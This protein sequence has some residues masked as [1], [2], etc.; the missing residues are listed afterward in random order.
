MFLDVTNAKIPGRKRPNRQE[1]AAIEK[2]SDNFL[3][4]D[5]VSQRQ[6]GLCHV[7]QK[8]GGHLIVSKSITRCFRICKVYTRVLYF[9]YLC[10]VFD[11]SWPPA[12]GGRC[13]GKLGQD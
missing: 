7:L 1:P 6:I 2:L 9:S 3:R 10:S 8:G 11:D 13:D 12:S 5:T 4:N